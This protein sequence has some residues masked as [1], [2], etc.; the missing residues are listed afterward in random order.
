MTFS[1][2]VNCE[3]HL[4]SDPDYVASCRR[5]FERQGLLVLDDFLTVQALE[6]IRQ[7]AELARDKAY[8]CK[9]LHTVYLTPADPSF[10]TDHIRNQQVVSTKGCVCDDVITVDSPLRQLYQAAVF[11]Q[12]IRAVTG[13][14]ELHPYA[15]K[16]SSI[17]LHYAD[18]GQELGWHFDN[19]SFAITL[20]IQKPDAGGDFEFVRDL[21]NYE[22]NEWNY[23]GVTSVLEGNAEVEVVPI[24][25]GTLVL[26]RGRNSIHRVSPNRGDVT[27]MMAV[28]AYNSEPG[29]ELSETAR[30][31]FYGRLN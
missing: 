18:R 15:D 22:R 12:F 13:E 25:P 21:R 10:P 31:T 27:R 19:S 5:E 24:E 8:F 4:L 2:V 17:N 7:S 9:Q 26:F 23:E 6:N 16:L 14:R 29:V 30:K 28:L 20:L 1:A 3:R 11:Q